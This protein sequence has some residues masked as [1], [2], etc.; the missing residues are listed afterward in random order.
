MK[1]RPLIAFFLFFLALFISCASA[2]IYSTAVY[3]SV[4]R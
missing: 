1:I 3:K 2:T 4:V